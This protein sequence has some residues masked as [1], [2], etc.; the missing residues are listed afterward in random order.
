M[1]GGASVRG[2]GPVGKYNRL[3]GGSSNPPPKLTC[4]RPSGF[5]QVAVRR[6]YVHW[7]ALVPKTCLGRQPCRAS[8]PLPL[9]EDAQ[10]CLLG[11]TWG[12]LPRV[13]GK[14]GQRFSNW[15]CEQM[16]PR[17]LQPL[18]PKGGATGIC[19]PE[20][21]RNFPPFQGATPASVP[22][23]CRRAAALSHTGLSNRASLPPTSSRSPHF[24]PL[25]QH[26]AA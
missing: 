15:H 3:V 6:N 10:G 26:T 12:C 11:R 22:R 7:E 18:P 9:R 1:R 5:L 16:A 4:G 13:Q 20:E 2:S 21:A 8:G 25:L 23:G 14:D 17:N 19:V 24:T